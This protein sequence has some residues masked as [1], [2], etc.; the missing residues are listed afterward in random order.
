ELKGA[1][2]YLPLV[3]WERL[4]SGSGARSVLRM[5]YHS[6]DTDRG[7]AS[8]RVL[9][10][11]T[12]PSWDH[13]PSG[14]ALISIVDD[15][16]AAAPHNPSCAI[17]V[18]ADS[19]YRSELEAHL[20][21]GDAPVILHLFG[22]GPRLDWFDWIRKALGGRAIDVFHLVAPTQLSEEGEPLVLIS[23]AP[24]SSHVPVTEIPMLVRPTEMAN[25]ACGRGAAAMVVTS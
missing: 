4:L 24:S 11:C 9:V 10:W 16:I 8:H 14:D 2:T 22:G 5:P 21:S 13:A 7:T 17:H 20:A 15:I 23:A 12:A 1:S 3:P 25:F 6:I 19:R 18:F